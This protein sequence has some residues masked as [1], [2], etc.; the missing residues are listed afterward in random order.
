MHNKRFPGRGIVTILTVLIMCFS[1]NAV[2][3][4][5]V[6]DDNLLN[7]AHQNGFVPVILSLRV[8]GIEYL[9][10]DCIRYS[11]RKMD[12]GDFHRSMEADLRLETAIRNVS[13]EIL[14]HLGS[15]DWEIHHTFSTLPVLALRVNAET[16]EQLAQLHQVAAIT[17]DRLMR[18]PEYQAN[19]S[20]PQEAS[21]PQMADAVELVRADSAWASG[22]TG[23]GEYVAILDSG[24]RRSHEA[25][26]GKAV[27]EQCYS[28]KADCPNG[29]REM[30]GPGAAHMYA[31]QYYGYDHG[32][33][34]SG[35]ATGNNG[36]SFRGIAPDANLIH[37]Q[38]FSRFSAAECNSSEPCVMSYNSDQL[39][40]LEFVFSR[41]NQL[42]IAAVSMSLGGGEYD[43]AA[44]CDIDNPNV[45]HA[46]DNLRA[47][48]IPTVISAGNDSLCNGLSAPACISSAIAIGA[49]TK[50]DQEASFSN[51][52]PQMLDFFAPGQSIRSATGGSNSSYQYWGGTSMAAP[53]VAGGFAIFRQYSRE[54]PV[55][56]L[57]TALE[58]SGRSVVT[59]CQ[60]G[61]EKPRINVGEAL[62]SL[63]SIAPPVNIQGSQSFNQSM[64][65]TEYINTLTW[66]ANPLN[67]DKNVVA[68]RV[69]QIIDNEMT[70]LAEVDA[71]TFSYRHRRV[72]KRTEVKYAFTSVDGEGEESGPSIFVLEFGVEQ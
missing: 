47:A 25:F 48:G 16:L 42:R 54:V 24:I 69:Y 53:M 38:V 68:Y 58:Y 26:Q 63:M 31:P 23:A 67:D 6:L 3:K 71:A 4:A 13:E 12:P 72:A 60:T 40:A 21:S 8:P 66:N 11:R 70:H 62:M 61:V 64:L 18:I 20:L 17:E 37:I 65:H 29:Q 44:A 32:T 50:N 28:L 36:G 33:H 43:N 34:V 51:F 22:Y 27:V 52:H 7:K 9:T 46:I 41:R 59:K 35:I 30:S 5:G 1:L 49:T 14:F 39:K 57:V 15:S 56:E 45:K 55:H 10:A 19:A 2:E